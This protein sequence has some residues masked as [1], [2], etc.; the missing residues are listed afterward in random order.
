LENSID[1]LIGKVST[2]GRHIAAASFDD[3][4][5]LRIVSLLYNS[6]AQIRNVQAGA[7]LRSLA[8]LCVACGAAGLKC[9]AGLLCERRGS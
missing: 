3:L 6:G 4:T 9:L 8:M 5:Q 7:R 2:E 1:L